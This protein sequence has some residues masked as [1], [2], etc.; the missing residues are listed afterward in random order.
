M[1]PDNVGLLIIDGVA[2]AHDWYAGECAT[3]HIN[4]RYAQGK[5]GNKTS[6]MLQ[7]ENALTSFYTACVAAGPKLCAIYQKSTDLVRD[8]V[9]RIIN[10]AHFRPRPVYDPSDP[11][12]TVFG[13]VDYAAITGELLQ[14]LEFPYSSGVQV[15]EALAALEK[16]NTSLIYSDSEA[17]G[18]AAL[19]FGACAVPASQP[20]QAGAL[21][22]SEPIA[23]GDGPLDQDDSFDAALSAYHELLK[24]SP[25]AGVWFVIEEPC[26]YVVIS[27]GICSRSSDVYL[28]QWLAYSVQRPLQWYVPALFPYILETDVTSRVI[29]NE[30]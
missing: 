21:D 13:V 6:A 2:N 26:S 15:V 29:H 8:R 18:I 11:S 17:S 9:D 3:V 7:T 12:Q 25:L 23:C 22:V 14:A 24:L 16:G 4:P 27:C 30:Y 19:G 28:Y 20:Y 1:F 5:K 10:D